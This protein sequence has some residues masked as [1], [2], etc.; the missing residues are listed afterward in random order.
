[1]HKIIAILCLLSVL[2]ACNDTSTLKI[3]VENP[4]NYDR[5]AEMIEIPV[6]ALTDKIALTDEAPAYVV[7]NSNGE[8]LPCQLT[9][10]GFLIFQADVKAKDKA[11]YTITAGQAQ[12]FAPKTYGRLIRE[13]KDDFAWENEKVAFRIYGEPLA[14]IDG[15]SNGLD[16]WYKR[17]SELIIDKWYRDDIAGVLS[18]HEDHGEG[19]DD[20]KV[21]RSLGAGMMAPYVSD[22]LWLNENFVGQKLL[23]QGPLRVSFEL[24]YRDIEVDGKTFGEKRLISLDAGSQLCKVT[25]IYDTQENIPVAAGIVKREGNDAILKNTLKNGITTLIYVEPFSTIADNVYIGMVFPSGL[26]RIATDTYT[27]T[28]PVSLRDE[29]FSHTLSVTTCSVG[30]PITYY[31]G[32]GW[33]KWGFPTA[34][35]FEQYIQRFAENIENPL[36]ITYN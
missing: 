25:Q 19:M 34:N 24:T 2:T 16:C 10:N 32:F 26:E 11:V 4:S 20:Y 12:A 21:G 29:T 35:D 33:S 7:Q 1:M 17:T 9:Y 18:Y 30:Q 15:P 36:I 5:Q 23:E 27:V 31:T 14:A 28:N 3:R 13:R 8:T 22:T 6:S